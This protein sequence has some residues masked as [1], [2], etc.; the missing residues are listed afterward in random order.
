MKHPLPHEVAEA[1][2]KAIEPHNNK[3]PKGR[4][5][6]LLWAAGVARSLYP[7]PAGKTEMQPRTLL[8]IRNDIVEAGCIADIQMLADAIEQLIDHMISKELG[9]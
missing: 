7:A 6:A 2:A 5:D 8:Q 9:E 3:G 4:V 1:I